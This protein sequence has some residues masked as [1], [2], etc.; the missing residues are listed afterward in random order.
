M[1]AAI[2]N[3]TCEQGA[4][5][6]REL[7]WRE[8]SGDPVD[9]T[10]Y[11]ARMTCRPYLGADEVWFTLSSTSDG[12]DLL[13]RVNG[14]FALEM[15]ATDTAELTPGT[16]VYDLELESSMGDVTRLMQGTFTVVGEVTT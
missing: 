3:I 9:L 1:L 14:K 15:T 8:A 11:T 13:D 2:Y 12:I 5:F 7:I 10:G 4:T 6:R 16:G